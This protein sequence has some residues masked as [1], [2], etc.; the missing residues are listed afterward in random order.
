MESDLEVFFFNFNLI[1]MFG[2]QSKSGKKK[3]TKINFLG[4]ETARWGG[5][6]HAKGWWPKSSCSPS[7]VCLP[8]V[9][10]RGIWGCP[11]NFA[12][13]SRTVRGVK[14]FVQKSLRKKSLC[15]FF[16]SP[17]RPFAAELPR[18]DSDTCLG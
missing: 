15:A 16:R 9:S 6:L 10:K 17:L 5:G 1:C 12:G 8:W 2:S 18:S 14:K 4:P 11:G 13:M 3:S 7:K